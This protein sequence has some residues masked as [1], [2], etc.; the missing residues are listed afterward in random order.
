SGLVPPG[1]QYRR[2]KKGFTVPEDNWMRHEF[3]PAVQE[4][5]DS[6]MMAEELG[7]VDAAKLRNLYS[8]F[9]RGGGLLNG[10]H[11]FRAFAFEMYLRRFVSHGVA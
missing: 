8:R 9:V 2:D 11:F 6:P 3:K 1:I 5:F 4:V 7:L 10:R